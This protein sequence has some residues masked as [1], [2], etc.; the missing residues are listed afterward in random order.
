MTKEW[1]EPIFDRTYSDIQQVQSNPELEHAKGAWNAEDL[2]RIEKNT[3]YCIEYML[4]KNIYHS[5]PG[6]EIKDNDYWTGDMV[7]V[8]GDIRRIVNNVAQITEY[9]R[10][11]NANIANDLPIIYPSTHIDW[12][13]ANSIEKALDILH[14]QPDPPK[15]YFKLTI[16]EGIVLRV[17]RYTGEIEEINS[18]EAL[19]A[20]DEVAIIRGIPS[21]PDAQYKIFQSWS[22]NKDDLQY[23]EHVDRQETKYLGQYRNVSFKAIFQTKIPRTLKLNNAY[24]SPT[25][26][27]KAESGPSSGV[28]FAGDN[29]MIIANRASLGK[30]FYE[31][32]GTK[33]AIDNIV[34]VTSAEDPSTAWLQM[35][36]CDVELTSFYVSA[37]GN[38]V[39]VNGGSGTGWYKY[40]EYVSISANVPDHYGFDNWSGDTSYLTDINSSWQSFEM[41]DRPL[42]FTANWSYRYSYND[43]QIING[44]ISYNDENVQSVSGVREAS[45]LRLVPTPPDSSQGIDYWSIEGVGSVSGNTFTVGDGN[46]IITG[47]YGPLRNLIINNKDNSGTSTTYQLVQ[48]HQIKIS[49]N[50][51]IGDYRFVRWEENGTSISTSNEITITMGETNRSIT[52]IY[53]YVS[54]LPTYT[55]KY[56]YNG[57]DQGTMTLTQGSEWRRNTNEDIGEKLRVGWYK[58]GVY[59]HNDDLY[60][61]NVYANT[62][63]EVKYRDK[64]SYTLTVVNG[65]ITSNG[66]TSGVYKEREAVQIIADDPAEGSTFINWQTN[67]AIYSVGDSKATT[68]RLGRGNGTVTARYENVR[69]ITVVTHSGTNTYP[70]IQGR[71]LKINALPAPDTWEWDTSVGWTMDEGG[72]GT[73]DNQYRSDTEFTAGTTD[74]TIRAHYKAIP[75]FTI[76]VINGYVGATE[77]DLNNKISTGQFLRDSSPYI[78]MKP[79]PDTRRFLNWDIKQGQDDDVYQPLAEKTRLRPLTHDVTLEALYYLPD[80]ELRFTLTIKRYEGDISET[81]LSVGQ[82][83]RVDARTAP[84]GLKFYRWEGD[85]KYLAHGRYEANNLVRM[86]AQNIML[87]ENFMDKDGIPTYHLYMTT[88]GECMYEVTHVNSDTGETEIREVWDTNHEYEEGTT[89]TIRT[90]NINFESEFVRWQVVDE[91]NEECPEYLESLIDEQTTLEMPP[92]DLWITPEIKD[93]TKYHMTIIDGQLTDQD[94]VEGASADVYFE[95]ITEESKRGEV[96]Y[97]FKRWISGPGTEVQIQDLKLYETGK[98][99]N[100]LVAGTEAEPQYISM[101]AKNVVI[102]A[103]YDTLYNVQLTDGTIDDLAE[104]EEPFYEVGS[105]VNITANEPPENK[106]FIRWE[107]DT[108][109][110]QNKWDPTTT[111]TIG[112]HS[113]KLTAIYALETDRNDIGY[114]LTNLKESNTIDFED[115]ILISGEIKTG[116]IVT[117]IIGHN[118][119]V[120]G[121]NDTDNKITIIRVTKI[122]KGGNVYE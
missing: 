64:E 97:R 5:D 38:K 46:A 78:I 75:Y 95:K 103:T 70:V 108:E 13:L 105:K 25:G 73:F 18:N 26:S 112:E 48:N 50:S 90:K 72:T 84:E 85:F 83:Q 96:K 12:I 66:Q 120:R 40:K 81:R 16:E 19:L 41:P 79:A 32:Q 116:C 51:K 122:N 23:L 11:N 30:K 1:I 94:Y 60:K 7:P 91:N 10:E 43:V 54:P 63:I 88:M 9:A 113:V 58:D 92:K 101:P 61:F 39:T 17:I 99:F 45:S 44:L 49:T 69:Q 2:N 8:Y 118:Y 111:I 76:T 15:D 86:P 109:Y 27:D 80:P 110:L 29:I 106:R 102:Q 34:G 4:E 98:Q 71:K 67:G 107:G 37:D 22:G 24:I 59:Q 89:V 35:P 52:A 6:L 119:I 121:V 14:D 74:A 87:E 47:H 104:G 82:E 68:V 53:T 62:T 20:E 77:A 3:A 36:D 56:I 65:H 31:W 21:E 100:V 117:D 55:V 33:E 57:I 42:T 115:I 114:N 93:K 28:Y